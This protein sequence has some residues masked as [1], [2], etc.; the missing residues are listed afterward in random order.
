[1]STQKNIPLRDCEQATRAQQASDS[2]KP[3]P[4][5]DDCSVTALT[6]L[7]ERALEL[8][9]AMHL[10][11]VGIDLSAALAKLKELPDREHPLDPRDR[12]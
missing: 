2:E 7:V 8:A 6:A 5:D 9:D 10:T 4:K 12:I 11:W 1:M 3:M